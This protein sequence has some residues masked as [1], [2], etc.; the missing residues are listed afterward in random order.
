MHDP[1]VLREQADAIRA[2]VVKKA[3]AVPPQFDRFFALDKERG[4]L[5]KEAD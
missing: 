4:A 5:L 3:G 2:G 1:R